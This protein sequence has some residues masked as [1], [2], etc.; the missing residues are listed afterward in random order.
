[1]ESTPK[2]DL[3][4]PESTRSSFS[5]SAVGAL[6]AFLIPII[7]FVIL[8]T[9]DLGLVGL[10]V[11]NFAVI[12]IPVGIVFSGIVVQMLAKR[13]GIQLPK[14]TLVLLPILSIAPMAV[15][16]TLGFIGSA[17]ET[18]LRREFTLS[19]AIQTEQVEKRFTE[20]KEAYYVYTYT[21]T[22]TSNLT[23]PSVNIQSNLLFDG[24]TPAGSRDVPI[25]SI[26][27]GSQTVSG[28]FAISS[29]S[30]EMITYGGGPVTLQF[31]AYNNESNLIT[32][33]TI[34]S[35]MDWKKVF[36]DIQNLKA[37]NAPAGYK[38]F[39]LPFRG[40][41]MDHPDAWSP[42]YSFLNGMTAENSNSYSFN[43]YNQGEINLTWNVPIQDEHP[44]RDPGYDGGDE[45]DVRTFMATNS[46]FLRTYD[47]FVQRG[48]KIRLC[49]VDPNARMTIQRM[50]ES[51][52][53]LP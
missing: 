7:P 36:E 12:C 10:V 24:T 32:N 37:E 30:Y 40:V 42:S 4:L 8:F 39:V 45:V 27:S 51:F 47:T 31:T 9:G 50:L 49:V 25:H 18:K 2:T 23:F 43:G 34:T 14:L 6:V 15:Y 22:I 19:G 41:Q 3:I 20:G 26:A 48:G 53:I 46:S 5:I 1:M 38:R 21:A 44:C 35:Q 17:K 28:E 33:I 11:L 29:P 52:R 13:K 16:M